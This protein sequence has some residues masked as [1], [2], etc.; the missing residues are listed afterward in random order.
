MPGWYKSADIIRQNLRGGKLPRSL[1]AAEDLLKSLDEI[2]THVPVEDLIEC[3]KAHVEEKLMCG[4]EGTPPPTRL[5]MNNSVFNSPSSRIARPWI[6][7][8]ILTR[9]P[10][11]NAGSGFF[12]KTTEDR[13]THWIQV[14]IPE[15]SL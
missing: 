2:N 15:N 14:S 3:V 7:P 9:S 4:A 11:G 13:Q 8:I 6:R 10:K 5:N 12:A 1:L